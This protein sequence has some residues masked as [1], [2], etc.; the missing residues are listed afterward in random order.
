MKKAERIII[1]FLLLFLIPTIYCF[2][3]TRITPKEPLSESDIK[4]KVHLQVTTG[5]LYFLKKHDQNKIWNIIKDTYPNC[6]PEYIQLTG[7]TPNYAVDDPA[8]LGDFNVYGEVIGT[9]SDASEGQI[10]L[11]NVKYSDAG[12]APITRDN[13]FVGKHPFPFIF[14]PGIVLILLI[15]LVIIKINLHKMKKS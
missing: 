6:N 11:F 13:T 2:T 3:P 14:F 5:P 1:V 15:A 4:V 9:Y 10:P 7:N 12:L 8:Y